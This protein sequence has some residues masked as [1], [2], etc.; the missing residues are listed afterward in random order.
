LTARPENSGTRLFHDDLA[1]FL[2]AYGADGL[3]AT[4]LEYARLA[5]SVRDLAVRVA[6]EVDQEG[7]NT[8]G[9]EG[10]RRVDTDLAIA[11]PFCNQ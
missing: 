8:W 9:M 1:R 5:R 4:H 2:L 11:R 10:L 3:D 7:I 6:N